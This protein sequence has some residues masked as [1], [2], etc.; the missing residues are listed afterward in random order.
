MK[1]KNR[2]AIV[3]GGCNGIG[4]SIAKRFREEGAFV[5]IL[6][7]EDELK[8]L[9]DISKDLGPDSLIVTGDISSL[10]DL[11]SFYKKIRERFGRIDIVV[12]NAAIHGKGF[13]GNIT[14]SQFDKVT[15]T[16]F[17]GT[18]FT[19]TESLAL[20]NENASIILLSSVTADFGFKEMALYGSTKAAI[21]YMA[22]AFASELV[23]VNVRVN[24]IS[25]G[26]INTAM[27]VSGY[28]KEEIATI[29]KE[30]I[31]N[32]PMRR[33]GQ[34]SEIASLALFL[35]SDDSLYITGQNINVDGGMSSVF[36]VQQE[37]LADSIKS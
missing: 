27:P 4:L 10:A 13:I 18:F 19:V 15:S 23:S 14:E 16:N 33:I 5:A 20:L 29:L 9:N 7:V 2:V 17:K 6:D 30:K 26:L 31:K 28:P 37:L 8:K 11:K 1:L 22:M 24:S 35:A 34:T 25:P 3:T 21:R 32:V 36:K 12:A